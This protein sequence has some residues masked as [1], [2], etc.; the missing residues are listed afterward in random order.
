MNTYD[1]LIAREE[2]CCCYIYENFMEQRRKTEYDVLE[3]KMRFVSEWAVLEKWC[4][5][6][7]MYARACSGE[8]EWPWRYKGAMGFLAEFAGCGS[9]YLE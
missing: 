4:W 8:T 1:L 3:R 6:C 5:M 7:E 9:Q 2:G